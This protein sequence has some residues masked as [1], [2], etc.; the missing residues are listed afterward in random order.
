MTAAQDSSTR[1]CP[2]CAGSAW[3]KFFEST[4]G[5]V[6][7]ADQSIRA[8]DL[9]KIICN[10]CG[11]VANRRRL[12][13]ETLGILYGEEYELNTTGVEE[14][15]FF[16]DNGPVPRSE[17][18]LRWLVP[19]LPPDFETLLEI[20]CGEGNLLAR[21]AVEFPDRTTIGIE[22]SG[23]AVELAMA[24][25]LEV[26]QGMV[27]GADSPLPAAD[28]I[29]AFGVL[30]HV[31]DISGF[32]SALSNRVGPRG[33]LVLGLPLQ[34]HGGYDIFF[35]EH[36]W[37]F[38]ADHVEALL[39]RNGL[40]V[41]RRAVND[42]VYQGFGLFIAKPDPEIEAPME[43]ARH[44]DALSNR[45]HWV[46]VF[47]RVEEQLDTLRGGRLAVFGAGEVLALL[48]TFTTL[49]TE[50]I[51]YSLDQDA[52]K[53]GTRRHGI[54]VRPMEALTTDP[55]D[56]VLLTVNERYHDALRQKLG[57]FDVKVLACSP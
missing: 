37:H 34:E 11:V 46:G 17:A 4:T 19:H 40:R 31:E 52:A 30:E 32:L 44:T 3:Q 14:H 15:I 9:E 25:G 41:T 23:R 22:G 7:T 54:P 36:V 39:A 24:K 43:I 13:D 8:G 49:A 12:D 28:L 42:P 50:R 35:A 2:V 27:F 57:A 45:D 33:H 10:C 55:V 38:T 48:L 1:V 51:L 20:G 5:R 18:V 47:R 56:A 26:T 21:L 6:M 16:T 53:M 29:L